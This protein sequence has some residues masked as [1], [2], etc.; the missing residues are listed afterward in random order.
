MT[1]GTW[2]PV[3]DLPGLFNRTAGPA[4]KTRDN[5]LPHVCPASAST[6]ATSFSIGFRD[7][8]VYL[9]LSI[10]LG[11]GNFLLSLAR[12]TC[13][14]PRTVAGVTRY[15][16]GSRAGVAGFHVTRI[17]DLVL[18]ILVTKRRGWSESVAPW[19]DILWGDSSF[20]YRLS[21]L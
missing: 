20:R 10:A 13:V 14:L 6:I 8:L 9:R 18:S 1:G 21:L 12:G 5:N 17:D 7:R 15:L 16:G 3:V 2:N 4:G 19:L 11:T